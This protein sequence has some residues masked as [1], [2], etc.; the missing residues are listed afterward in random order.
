LTWLVSVKGNF[1]PLVA[2]AISRNASDAFG[3]VSIFPRVY[4]RIYEA[5]ASAECSR[6]DGIRAIRQRSPSRFHGVKGRSAQKRIS[7]EKIPA[8]QKA[9]DGAEEAQ[10]KTRHLWRDWL[11]AVNGSP[12][13]HGLVASTFPTDQFGSD[14]QTR[15]KIERERSLVLKNDLYDSVIG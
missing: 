13:L 11:D 1:Y 14:L 15:F 9:H 3:G 6:Q 7:R 8:T 12:S 10:I 2:P 5:I 4:N